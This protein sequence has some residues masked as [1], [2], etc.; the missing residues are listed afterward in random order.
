[1][2]SSYV[3]LRYPPDIIQKPRPKRKHKKPFRPHNFFSHLALDCGGAALS[4]KSLS[5]RNARTPS[6]NFPASSSP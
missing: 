3:R 4:R 6:R 5:S 1:M 2:L